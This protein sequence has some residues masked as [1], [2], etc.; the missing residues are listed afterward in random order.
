MTN[1]TTTTTT[2]DVARGAL[3]LA[4]GRWALDAAHV[5]VGFSIRHLGVAKV[6]GQFA[7][8]AAELVVGETAADSSVTA[9]VAVASIDT[10]NGDRD[11]HV[12]SPDLLDVETRPTL[13]FRSTALRGEADGWTLEGD[14]TIGDV[15]RPVTFDVEFGG[16]APLPG[17]DGLHAGFEARGEIRR[18]DFGLHFGPLDAALG[19]VVKIELDVEF[20]EPAA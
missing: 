10:G 9:T 15:T 7:E 1:T 18:H 6:R 14:L 4:P 5:H 16:A 3:P 20:L 13:T 19:N 12:L 11:A 8:V 2:A 17:Q